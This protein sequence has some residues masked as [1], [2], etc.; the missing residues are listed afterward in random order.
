MI[1]DDLSENN[2]THVVSFHHKYYSHSVST[3]LFVKHV[4]LRCFHATS[5]VPELSNDNSHNNKIK[6]S[7]RFYFAK[8]IAIMWSMPDLVLY[9]QRSSENTISLNIPNDMNAHSKSDY[10][11]CCEICR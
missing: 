11:V 8:S 7:I 4:N 9:R 5:I 1:T 10:L 2:K 6:L 3:F